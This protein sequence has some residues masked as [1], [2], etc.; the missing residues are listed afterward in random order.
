MVL[1]WLGAERAPSHYLSQRWSNSMRHIYASLDLQDLTHWPLEILCD[2]KNVIFNLAL[3]IGIFK[4]SYDNN[5]LRRMPQ[6][7]T[8]DK[9]TVG[10]GNGLV[11]SGNK[12]VPEPVLTKISNAIWCH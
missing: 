12:P 7:L 2:F 4:S 9:S 11:P 3:L 1:Q 5:V 6:D 10:P 8:D